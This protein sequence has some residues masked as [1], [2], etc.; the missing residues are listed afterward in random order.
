MR[1]AG[2]FCVAPLAE[3]QC[4]KL[5]AICHFVFNVCFIYECLHTNS[6]G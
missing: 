2:M 5:L 1:L 3:Y 4:L 6:E